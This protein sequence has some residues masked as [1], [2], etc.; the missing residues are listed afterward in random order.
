MT[1]SRLASQEMFYLLMKLEDS[2]PSSRQ[3][4]IGPY[5]EADES[6]P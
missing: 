2:S 4:D 6:S 1:N 3:S 5:P